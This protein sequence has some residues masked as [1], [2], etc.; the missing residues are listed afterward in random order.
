[1][2]VYAFAEKTRVT[3]HLSQLH[4]RKEFQQAIPVKVDMQTRIGG[5]F[6]ECI[7]QTGEKIELLYGFF[8]SV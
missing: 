3:A 7:L 6:S 4:Y 5:C 8:C 1:M 2:T